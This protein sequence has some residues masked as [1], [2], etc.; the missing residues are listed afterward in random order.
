M[1]RKDRAV[2]L[3]KKLGLK[4]REFTVVATAPDGSQQLFFEKDTPG[5]A[6]KGLFS[7]AI[8]GEKKLYSASGHTLTISWEH[9]EQ[10]EMSRT[11]LPYVDRALRND[12]RNVSKLLIE[13]HF[14]KHKKTLVGTCERAEDIKEDEGGYLRV[15]LD[16]T[17]F[18]YTHVAMQH[19]RGLNVYDEAERLG[20]DVQL[21]DCSHLC[22]RTWCC[23]P[24]HL[25]FE[26]HT[27]NM[28]RALCFAQGACK[29]HVSCKNCIFP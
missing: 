4:K 18:R 9:P 17:W 15:N 2:P 12:I 3:S 16:N 10:P 5:Q 1:K 27:V 6:I 23:N 22:N 26:P 11:S 13:K 29:G 21:C 7:Q 24:E 20:I 28:A 8:S 25:E 14:N 19:A